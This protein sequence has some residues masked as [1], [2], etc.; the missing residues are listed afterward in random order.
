MPSLKIEITRNLTEVVELTEPIT[1]GRGKDN[2]IILLDGVI[3]RTHARVYF[4]GPEVIIEDLKSVNGILVNGQKLLLRSLQDKDVIQIGKN[5]IYFSTE[6]W[7]KPTKEVDLIQNALNDYNMDEIIASND[8]L[9]TFPSDDESINQIYEICRRKFE[10]LPVTDMEKINLDAALNE[11]VGNAQRHGHNYQVDLP[12]KLR[13]IHKPEKL[14]MR[15]TDQGDGFDYRAELHKKKE[16]T[17]VEEARERYKS[18]GYGGLGIMLMLKCVN[19]VEY[20]SIGN[21][22]TLTKFLGEAAKKFEEEEKLK[23]KEE[24]EEKEAMEEIEQ[25]EVIDAQ[26]YDEDSFDDDQEEIF[27]GIEISPDDEE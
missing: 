13:Y 3:S 12:I 6:T 23:N 21:E 5:K 25:P 9:F 24:K 16:G 7:E 1:I 17:A 4:D 15:V 19:K 18:G 14:V 11:G 8:V 2:N 26:E 22:V 20:N 27:G 10:D